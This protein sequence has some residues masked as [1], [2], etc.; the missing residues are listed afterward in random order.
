MTDPFSGRAVRRTVTTIES[1][2]AMRLREARG[3]MGWT[4]EQAAQKIGISRT[5]VTNLEIGRGTCTLRRFVRICE[6]YDV[7]ADWLLWGDDYG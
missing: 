3:W 2:F 7:S 6:V 5:Q 4:Q 1:P